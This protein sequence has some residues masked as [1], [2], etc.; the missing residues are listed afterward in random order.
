MYSTNENERVM[1]ILGF[2]LDDLKANQAG[3]L[4]EKQIE[5]LSQKRSLQLLKLRAVILIYSV[6]CL[7]IAVGMI[8]VSAKLIEALMFI[9]LIGAIGI[10]SS[11]DQWQQYRKITDDLQ[12][13][14]VKFFEGWIH[15][16]TLSKSSGGKGSFSGFY[17][18][19]ENLWLQID[20]KT[21]SALRALEWGRVYYTPYTQHVIAMDLMGDEDDAPS[22]AEH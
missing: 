15:S 2:S 13:K 6:I 20:K 21:Y 16:E 18:H 11:R 5:R 17:L 19:M 1:A 8:S 7:L 14:E 4:S 3:T 9:A 10:F 12:S 22:A